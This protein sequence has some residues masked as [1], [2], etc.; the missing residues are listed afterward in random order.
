MISRR[1]RA[2]FDFFGN[3]AV[4]GLILL[5][6]RESARI[7][8]LRRDGSVDDLEVP[9]SCAVDDQEIDATALQT[10]F[11]AELIEEVDLP[12]VRTDWLVVG[13]VSAVVYRILYDRD[14]WGIRRSRVR[15][16]ALIV[17]VW[18]AQLRLSLDD[19]EL[20]HSFGVGSSVGAV[21][22]R[23]KYGL[24]DD[25]PEDWHCWL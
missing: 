16:W 23:V 3:L 24:L 1:T 21:C 10:A 22:Y 25:L 12:T 6:R 18:I 14:I 5:F 7:E 13:V 15:R 4:V 19:R 20:S 2:I 17:G 8:R 9:E 11:A